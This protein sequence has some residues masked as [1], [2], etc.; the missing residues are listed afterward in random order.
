MP[1]VDMDIPPVPFEGDYFGLYDPT[2][3]GN[4]DSRAAQVVP[5][6]SGGVPDAVEEDLDSR[7]CNDDTRLDG[8]HGDDDDSAEVI[9]RWTSPTPPT[10]SDSDEEDDEDAYDVVA[11]H[12]G[13]PRPRLH[14][15]N[16]SMS[17]D[18]GKSLV[19]SD[20]VQVPDSNPA[21]SAATEMQAD[22]PSHKTFVVPYPG[23]KA[24]APTSTETDRSST[25]DYYGADAEVPRDTSPYWPFASKLDWEIAQWAKKRGPGSTSVTELLQIET[26]VERLGLSYATSRELNNIIDKRMSA[27]RPPFERHEIDVAGEIFEVYYRDIIACARALFGD[28]EFAPHLLV[29]P[30]RHYTDEDHT[31]RMPMQFCMLG[32]KTWF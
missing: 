24:G 21:A 8:T 17:H 3:L 10:D 6:I 30:E 15:T 22:A 2:S 13:S 28:P 27:S 11:W 5:T 26:V 12:D 16:A 14:P 19:S 29:V 18:D 1:D 20:P 31:V 23:G 4:V 25:Y 7:R 32:G 9:P